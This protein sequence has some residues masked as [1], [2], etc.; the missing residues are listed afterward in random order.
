MPAYYANSVGEFLRT[1]LCEVSNKLT[2]GNAEFGFR[3]MYSDLVKSWQKDIAVL[4]RGLS[5]I[6]CD[7]PSAS[8][9]GILLEFPIPR[10]Q[11]RIDAVILARDVIFV[12]EFKTGKK[13]A[14]ARRQVED[15]ALDLAAFHEASHNRT[16]VPI[17]VAPVVAPPVK[18]VDRSFPEEWVQPVISVA[19]DEL[20]TAILSAF[21]SYSFPDRKPIFWRAWDDGPY[22]PVPTIIEAATALFAGISIREITHTHA[23]LQNLTATTQFILEAVRKAHRK[24]QKLICFV[25]G[26]PGAGKTLAGL[27]LAHDPRI[28]GEGRRASVFMS[29]NGPLIKILRQALLNDYA[30]RSGKRKGKARRYVE[31][32][33]QNIHEFVKTNLNRRTSQ[34]NHEHVIV[35][36]EAQRAWSAEKN[37]KQ[38]SSKTSRWH[39]SEPEMVLSIMDRHRDWAAIVAL[40]GGGQE[41]HEGEAGLKAWGEALQNSFRHW[42]I[43]APPEALIGG[44]SVAGRTLFDGDLRRIRLA[45]EPILHL[46][47]A[48]RSYRAKA[49]AEW[50]NR[51]LTGDAAKAAEL[52]KKFEN[53]PIVLT[54]NLAT[55]KEWLRRKTRGERRCGLIGSSGAARLRALG[56][57][58]SKGF[59]DGYL[60]DRWFLAPPEDVRSSFQLEVV[61]TEFE[62]QGL[63]LDNIGLCWGGDLVWDSTSHVWRA[64]D[65]KVTKW[66]EVR[67]HERYVRAVNKYRVLLTRAREGLLIWVP[68][69]DQS[70]PTRN[71][72]AMDE[73]ADYLEQCGCRSLDS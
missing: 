1:P 65:F 14:P 57:E 72:A 21:N 42:Q 31:G 40:I 30:I 69:G 11:R 18:N 68:R 20:A 47:T 9:W 33:V 34:P 13:L 12:L 4:Q 10:R 48:A 60:Y 44:E 58:T 16:I 50:V 52:T 53:F 59:R 37:A 32:L 55:A 64:F 51:V 56:I 43:F 26:V 66:R 61:A 22:H 70:D 25:T 71:I 35:F 8:G 39:V 54:R 7:C 27:N 3:S 67:S 29:G 5:S 62:I 28:R 24:N 45:R 49:M 63:E 17:V 73:T 15:Y 46:R 36:D 2:V 38:H 19:V 23:G 41:I 6:C